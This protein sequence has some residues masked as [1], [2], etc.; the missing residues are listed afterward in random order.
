MKKRIYMNMTLLLTLAILLIS[1]ALCAVFYRQ[2]T[3]QVRTILR[4]ETHMLAYGD[5]EYF[6]K[7]LESLPAEDMRVTLMQEDGTVLF[8]NTVD[9]RDMGNHSE[10]EEV[11][12]ALFY[13]EGEGRRR[14]DTFGEKT[15]YFALRL[16]NGEILR[17][18]QTV[19]YIWTIFKGP[20]PAVIVVIL[21]L[22][23]LSHIMVGRLT[24]KVVE[25]MNRLT[26]QEGEKP[27]Y[28]ELGPFFAP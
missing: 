21:F 27:P 11:Q 17:T 3:Q 24:K 2:I 6:L 28:D 10:R 19:Q 23:A 16:E 25:P 4:R 8:D 12:E 13:G 9:I 20:L 1:V 26:F 18:A 5:R 7:R 14:S 15:Y 22:L